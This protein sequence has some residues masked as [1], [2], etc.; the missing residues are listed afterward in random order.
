MMAANAALGRHDR[1]GKLIV[2]GNALSPRRRDGDRRKHE[3]ETAD[4][5]EAQGHDIEVVQPMPPFNPFGYSCGASTM[6]S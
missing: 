1:I 4:L 3:R 5:V 6:G 2:I